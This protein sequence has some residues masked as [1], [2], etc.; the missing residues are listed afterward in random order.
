MKVK[1]H[2]L[3][4]GCILSTDVRSLTKYPIVPKKTVIDQKYIDVLKAF[5]IKEVE[6]E[7]T[8]VNGEPFH[9]VDARDQSEQANKASFVE[10]YL[11]VVQEYKKLFKSW[12]SGAPINMP[13]VRK[14]LVPLLEQGVQTPADIF[15]L[16]HYSTSEDY[17]YHHA[18]TVAILS[19]L[20]GKLLHFEKGDWIQIGVAGA[21]SDSGMAKIDSKIL[22]KKSSLSQQEYEEVK[23]HPKYSYEM[24]KQVK[25]VSDSVRKAVV[26]H[27]ERIDGSG[28]PLGLTGEKLHPFGKIIAVADV[29]HAMTSERNYRSKQ[30]PFK[31][32]ESILHDEF[33]KFD[34]KVIQALTKVLTNFSTGTRVKLSNNQVGEIVFIEPK[35]PTRPMIKLDSGEIIQL[36]SNRQLFIEEIL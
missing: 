15:N 23:Q 24:L 2:Q 3:K 1:T 18:V 20:L 27:H 32:L 5:L 4:E 25:V 28:Y 22:T 11:Q 9:P 12:Q 17:L 6:V 29:F 36:T 35:H 21:L 33:G 7:P 13:K 31:V 26:Q 30:S 14:V 16:H 10:R 19:A 8:L 34:I